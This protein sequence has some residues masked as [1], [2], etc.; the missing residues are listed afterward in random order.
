LARKTILHQ[1]GSPI[2][3]FLMHSFNFGAKHGSETLTTA[4]RPADG[5]WTQEAEW[6]KLAWERIV[7]GRG[8]IGGLM[9]L[10]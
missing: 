4:P 6:A 7:R 2:D 9:R 1:F 5:F 10:A 3:E 8:Q